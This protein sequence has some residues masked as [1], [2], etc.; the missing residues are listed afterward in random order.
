MTLDQCLRRYLIT[1]ASAGDVER[2]LAICEQAIEGGMTSVQLRAKG[3]SDR[4]LLHAAHELRAISD[5]TGTLFIVNDRVDIALASN[6]DGVHLGVD[7]LPVGA[8][9]ALLGPDKVIG[10]SP[11]T[12]DDRQIAERA[13]INYLGIGP[14]FGTR[15]KGDAGEA[16]GLDRFAGLVAESNVPVVGIGGITIDDARSVIEAGACGVAIVGAVFFAT[17]PRAAASELAAQAP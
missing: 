1:D 17:D 10:Y 5:R 7:D 9:R 16:L 4:E 15:T 8:A 6:A 2:L 12:P 13:G 3:W 11:E 14:V